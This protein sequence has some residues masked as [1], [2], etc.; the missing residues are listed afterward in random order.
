MSRIV[1]FAYGIVSRMVEHEE[2]P[3]F[4][5]A[6]D[7]QAEALLE[8]IQAMLGEDE[9]EKLFGGEDGLLKM[10]KEGGI[11]KVLEK[12]RGGRKPRLGVSVEP[13]E[14]AK[15]LRVGRVTPASVAE[16]AGVRVGDVIVAFDGHEIDD[17]EMLV[18]AVRAA[19]GRVKLVIE[20]DGERHEL[21]ADMGGD[22]GA[23]GKPEAPRKRWL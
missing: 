15:G 17:H 23:P 16:R 18:A 4:A 10:F 8:Q 3:A 19:K 14:G 7:G 6:K 20:R 22:G 5:R 12:L 13:V 1:R 2:R 21:E 9:L 11:N